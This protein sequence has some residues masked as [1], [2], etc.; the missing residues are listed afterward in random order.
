LAQ[1]ADALN[2]SASHQTAS[3]VLK[4]GVLLAGLVAAGL[5]LKYLGRDIL[6]GAV[7]TPAGTAML[8][9]GGGVLTAAGVP[10]QA[11]AFAGGYAFGAW[12]GGALALAAQMLGCGADFWWARTIARDWARGRLRG[13]LARLDRFLSARP[14][15]ATLTLRLLPVGNN[16]ALNLLAGASGLRTWPFLAATLI[17]YLPQTA[18]FALAGSGIHLDHGTQLALGLILFAASA[19]LGAM[20]LKTSSASASLVGRKSEAPSAKPHCP[21]EK[22]LKT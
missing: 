18:I 6:A 8:V 9:A 11:V 2:A 19:T 10:R 13:R 4:G 17:G 14:F 21:Q 12:R 7:P 3:A 1:P 5:A 22:P 20:L 16:L 15:V